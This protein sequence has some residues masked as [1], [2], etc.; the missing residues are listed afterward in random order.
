M[1]ARPGGGWRVAVEGDGSLTLDADVVI[2]AADAET[3]ARLIRTVAPD[4]ATALS[5]LPTAPIAVCCL[6]FRDADANT[7]GMD[8]AAYGFLVARGEHPRLLGCQY[9]SSTFSGR[10]PAGGVLLR[11]LVGGSGPGFEPELVDQ[12]DNDHR[13][14]RSPIC[15]S[16]RAYDGI[17][18]SFACGDIPTG[19]HSTRPAT[20]PGLPPSTPPFDGIRVSTS[21][22]T[23]YAASASTR[24]FARQQR[25]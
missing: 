5:G 10:A 22:D 15:A 25:W 24:A 17:P 14:T 13:R 2:L 11:A 18:I 3:S 7:L 19:S 8:L 4:A 21:W 23:P 1:E 12:P 6:G 9:E 20:P 16:S